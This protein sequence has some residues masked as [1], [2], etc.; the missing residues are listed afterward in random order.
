MRKEYMIDMDKFLNGKR[1][2]QPTHWRQKYVHALEYVDAMFS[3]NTLDDQ[4]G[5][6]SGRSIVS[7]ALSNLK[8]WKGE[9]AREIKKELKT[10]LK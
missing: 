1:K 7:Y 4:Y 5:W 6:D 10:M 8:T 2:S 9:K 3:L